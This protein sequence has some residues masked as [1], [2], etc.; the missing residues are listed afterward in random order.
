M[1]LDFSGSVVVVVLGAL[2][3]MFCVSELVAVAD[4]SALVEIVELLEPIW[5]ICL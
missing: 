1:V 4:L 3:V 2:A 5:E